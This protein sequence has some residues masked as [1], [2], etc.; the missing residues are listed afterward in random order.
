MSSD[1][2][3]GKSAL[4]ITS[5]LK[6]A[7]YTSYTALMSATNAG[8][9]TKPIIIGGCSTQASSVGEVVR[10]KLKISQ[11]SFVSQT[12]PGCGCAWYE[13]FV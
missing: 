13:T 12:A 11:G 2:A 4:V 8:S 3:E 9:T 10:R 7:K 6:A 5:S 1:V